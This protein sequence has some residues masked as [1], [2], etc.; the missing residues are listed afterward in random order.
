MVVKLSGEAFSGDE[1]LGISP[2]VVFHL[3]K[4]IAAVVADGVQLAAVVGGGNMFRG[5]ELAERG[6]DRARADYMGMLGTV[7]NCLALQDVLEKLGVETRVQT[8]ITM[9]QVAEPYIPRRAIRHLEKGRVVIFGAGLG[10]PFFSTDTCAA[11]R[12]LEIGAEAVLKGTQVDG[13]YDADPRRS[14]DATRFPQIDYGEVL[15]REL[16]F[17]DATAVSLC[18]DNG[19]PIVVFDLMEEGNVVRA[20]RGEKIGT[21]I[22]RSGELTVSTA[23]GR[24][25]PEGMDTG[26][27]VIDETLLEAE[28]KM[29]KAVAVAK[30][31]FGAIR[32]GRAH[33]AMFAK[34]TAEYYGTQTPV[35]QLASFHIPEPRMVDRPAVRQ[36][37]AEQH[38]EGH[39]EQRPGG[40]PVQRRRHHPGRLPRAVRRA[41]QG[42]HQGGPAQGR[43]QP[44]LHPQHPAARQGL[45]GQDGQGGR[46]GRGRGA[47]GAGGSRRAH[48][49]LRRAGGRPAPAQ[50]SRAS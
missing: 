29:E 41:A 12:A 18:M 14:P 2:D 15:R 50:G 4:E 48:A 19:L 26:A 44:G 32:T 8:A 16:K 9:G 45:P 5:R 34:I 27:A 3:A 39:P 35:N 40:E 43:G 37:L 38:R 7:I 20:V 31:D 46:R 1:P 21:L 42:L 24:R 17:M 47:P 22:C 30:E 6:I 23:A 25:E 36:V 13:V 33:P 10:A 49:H 28:E 11:Q